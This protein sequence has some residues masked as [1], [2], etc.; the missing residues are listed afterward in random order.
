MSAIGTELTEVTPAAPGF[1]P[2][3]GVVPISQVVPPEAGSYNNIPETDNSSERAIDLDYEEVLPKKECKC[4]GFEGLDE[5]RKEIEDE[6]DGKLEHTEDELRIEFNQKITDAEN[7]LTVQ[8]RSE[9]EQTAREIRTSVS[10]QLI[11]MQGDITEEYQSAISQTAREIRTDVSHE[12]RDASG[13]VLEASRSY[14]E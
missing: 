8:Y 9:L 1:N 10:E 5:F 14:T 2:P 11:D 12:I 13:E 4:A 3:A 7:G 6:F